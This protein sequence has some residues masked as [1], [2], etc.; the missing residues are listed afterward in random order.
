MYVVGN[1]RLTGRSVAHF[2]IGARIMFAID[3]VAVNLFG[4]S[5]NIVIQLPAF[6]DFHSGKNIVARA[7]TEIEIRIHAQITINIRPT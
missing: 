5:M 6:A 3:T 7:Q 1:K 2:Q 4:K